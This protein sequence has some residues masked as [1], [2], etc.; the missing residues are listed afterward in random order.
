MSNTIRGRCQN[1]AKTLANELGPAWHHGEQRA[2]RRH[3]HGTARGHHPQQGGEAGHLR[4]GSRRA[5][6][7]G[8]PLRRFAKPEEVAQAVAFS[9]ACGPYINGINLPVDGG[10][11]A[12]L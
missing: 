11:T 1:W 4:G 7:G 3:R 9:Q 10:R 12:C 2:A 5:H 6:E 8:D